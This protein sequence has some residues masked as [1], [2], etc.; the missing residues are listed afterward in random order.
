MEMDERVRRM[1]CE[2]RAMELYHACRNMLMGASH[3]KLEAENL[4][5]LIDSG[6]PPIPLRQ[7]FRE[8]LQIGQEAA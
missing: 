6:I 1:V 3:S 2:M 5:M 7:Q 4:L 8:Q